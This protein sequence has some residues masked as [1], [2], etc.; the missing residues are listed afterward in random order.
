MLPNT[1]CKL[2]P[3]LK[4]SFGDLVT[5]EG[6]RD[7]MPLL[8]QLNIKLYD[9][10]LIHKNYTS[11]LDTDIEYIHGIIQVLIY[12]LCVDLRLPDGCMGKQ[13]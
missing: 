11:Q 4:A 8:T 1:F 9:C 3:L 12:D 5:F 10:S 2:N 7:N 6:N 13:F